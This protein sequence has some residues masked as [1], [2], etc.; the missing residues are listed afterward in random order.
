MTNPT[1]LEVVAAFRAKRSEEM[2]AAAAAEAAT[3]SA[4]LAYRT[5]QK[6]LVSALRDEIAVA[7]SNLA[8]EG[9]VTFGFEETAVDGWKFSVRSRDHYYCYFGAFRRNG[10]P[11]CYYLVAGKH[12]ES[13]DRTEILIAAAKIAGEHEAFASL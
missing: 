4:A 7:F 3:K 6:A 1:L 2:A 8:E 12:Q 9:L 11:W 10:E 13:F 5:E